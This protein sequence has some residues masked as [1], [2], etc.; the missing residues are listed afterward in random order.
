MPTTDFEQAVLDQLAELQ[1]GQG[2]LKTGQED[3]SRQ[4]GTIF[5]KI[6][7]NG[8]PGISQRLTQ[9]ETRCS[10]VQQQKEREANAQGAR[11]NYHWALYAAAFGSLLLIAADLI[12]TVFFH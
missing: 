2:A 1:E 8:Q 11:E 12:K 3:L 10:A 9:I 4:V 7:G 6:E 5:K